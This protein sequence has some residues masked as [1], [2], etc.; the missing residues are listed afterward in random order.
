MIT[1]MFSSTK[2]QPYEL[3][4]CNHQRIVNLWYGVSLFLDILTSLGICMQN[5]TASF[6]WGVQHH[7]FNYM[8]RKLS[9][10]LCKA[11]FLY[12]NHDTLFSSLT[13]AC[14]KRAASFFMLSFHHKIK[15]STPVQVWYFCNFYPHQDY[16]PSLNIKHH[17]IT[18]TALWNFSKEL[19]CNIWFF[20]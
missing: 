2:C 20:L 14:M 12:P 19:S 4:I 5:T 3:Q 18:L 9:M 13:L 7:F 6:S 10:I 1:I 8:P 16:M 11:F 15:F 17:S